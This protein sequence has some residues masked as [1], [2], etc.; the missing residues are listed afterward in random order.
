VR[1]LDRIDKAILN[2]L[3][4]DA[5]TPLREIAERVHSSV[6]TCQRR[7]A[8]LRADGVLL[9]EVALVD[10]VLAGRPLTVFVSVELERQNTDILKQFEQRMRS[11]PEVM[12]CYEVA[13]EFD[14]HL[15]VTI[16]SME[17]FSQFSRRVFTAN[18]NVVNVKSLFAMQCSKFE[19]KLTL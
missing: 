1:E 9:K 14:F 13:G 6:A 2:L 7:I 10:R 4:E 15:V 11:E 16:G 18:N 12:S 3:Q 5:A 8:Q 17:E 19:T